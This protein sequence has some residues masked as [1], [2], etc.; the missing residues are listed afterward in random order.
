MKS[1]ATALVLS[2][3]L[4]AT[5]AH[6]AN[7]TITEAK[8]EGGNLI[9]SGTTPQAN[10]AVKLDD[11]FNATSNG[12]KKFTFTLSN[13]LPPDCIVNLTAGAA[14]GTGVVANCGPKGVSPRGAWKSA[15]DYVVDDLVVWQG[16][17]WR[18]KIAN[19]N[20]KPN[21]NPNQWQVFAAKGD[22]GEAGPKGAAGP[23]GDTGPQGAQG[24]AGPQGPQGPQGSQG[25]TGP[26]GPQGP[27]GDPGVSGANGTGTISLAANA[28]ANGRCRDFTIG[29][30]GTKAGDAIV[31]S[32][33]GALA[34][35]MLIYG[36][37]VA[38]DNTGVMKVCNFTGG[39]SPV[40]TD[41]QIR[42]V[43][44]R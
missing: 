1:L 26:Q 10:Q 4:F 39:T 34:E 5:A 9:V 24:P 41:L 32:A 21:N 42:V 35:G 18:A 7:V 40:V 23:A 44:F 36:A 30:G 25:F 20:K 28:I 2:A 31:I 27:K 12:Q 14:T 15:S 37:R 8:V 11:K 22:V 38:T 13:Y 16:T 17:T 33:K 6:A 19:T 29:F 3:G 43:T